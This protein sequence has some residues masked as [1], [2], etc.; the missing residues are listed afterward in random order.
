MRTAAFGLL[1]AFADGTAFRSTAALAD[2]DVPRQEVFSGIET[3]NNYT[4]VYAGGGYA[5]RG[6][7]DAPGW[8]L[9]A[10]GAY[11]R[12]S[13][14]GALFDGSTF[15]ATH[16]EGTASFLSA[17]AGYQFHCGPVI[18]K[19]SPGSRPSTSASPPSIR[20]IRSRGRNSACG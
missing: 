19:R 1:L 20:A 14:G 13:Y 18:A 12:Y 2:D 5:L 10:V 16:F 11:G 4:S 9:R 7:F 6:G 17:Q 15:R 8:R 3:S